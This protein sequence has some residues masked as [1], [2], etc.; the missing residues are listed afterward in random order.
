MTLTAWRVVKRGH[1]A[2]D[3]FSG[4]GAKKYGGRWNSPGIPMVYTSD[5]IALAT[6]EI[7][8]HMDHQSDFGKFVI[9][10]ARFD[11]ALVTEPENIPPG[12][13]TY[14]VSDVSMKFGDAWAKQ[15][16]TPVLKVPSAVVPF[17]FNYILNP[18][19]PD[20]EQIQIK[21]SFPYFLDTRLVLKK[22]EAQA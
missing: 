16:K 13:D 10:P 11:T 2:K 9:F 22:K 14:P 5:S 8:I 1:A 21:E 7:Y 15:G 4:E 3:P 20:F 12:W 6:L 18:L 17:E 19:H